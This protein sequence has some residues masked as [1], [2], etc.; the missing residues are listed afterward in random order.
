MKTKRTIQF[1]LIIVLAI[2]CSCTN[3]K[4]TLESLLQEMTDR[5]N[6]TYFPAPSYTVKQFSSY[7]QRSVSATQEG[8]FANRDYTHFIRKENNEG[9]REFVLFDD[10]GPGAVVRYW[11]TFAG[12]GASEGT[13]RI[14]IDNSSKPVL[15]DS[16]LKIL[17][18]GLLAKEPLSTSVSPK[19]EYQRRGHNLYLP[20][21]YAKH[22]KITYE[23]D[24]IKIDDNNRKP[25]IYYNITY[26]TYEKGTQ[27]ESFSMK[28]LNR[29]NSVIEN[30][31][32]KLKKPEI[33]ISQT[34][35]FPKSKLLNPGDTL[36]FRKYEKNR[37]IRKLLINLDAKDIKQALR[38]T[39]LSITFDNEQTVWC[40]IG[41]FFGTGYQ[42]CKSVTWYSEVSQD[43]LMISR[44]VMPFHENCIVKIINYGNQ[45]VNLDAAVHFSNYSWNNASMHFGCSWHE[46]HHL[47]TSLP[48]EEQIDSWHFDVNYID[49]EGRGVYAGDALTVFNTAD[50]W[51]GEGDEKIFVDDDIFPSCLGTGT[52]DY[53]GYAWCR[54]ETF[55]HP[56]IAQPAGNGNFHPG[57][58]VNMRYRTLDAM[59]F[60]KKIESDI[61]MWH[62]AKT[63]INYAMTSYWYAKPGYSSNIDPAPDL[64]K[65][66]VPVKRSDIYPPVVNE[67]GIIEG[68]ILGVVE[69]TNG[70]AGTQSHDKF[71]WSNDAQL[72]WRGAENGDLLKMNFIISEKGKYKVSGQFTKAVDYGM[73]N[74][75]INGNPV[76]GKFNGYL[77]Q[78]VKA[79]HFPLGTHKLNS[80]KN[81][82][83]IEI[84]GKDPQANIGYM[85]GI[86]FL[87]F[88]PF[89]QP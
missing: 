83:S 84:T 25:S 2:F 56:F 46:Y 87:K 70:T 43:G 4:I 20:L 50:A 3:E 44:W 59:P 68:E 57:M 47:N 89:K 24:S 78:G 31:A 76:N 16:V 48:K 27:V 52:E 1:G 64:V 63:K 51:W 6:L 11:M 75:K 15:E 77:S 79:F 80:G 88:E 54:P 17:S 55:T 9:R 7:D 42:A 60:N 13:L 74:I 5:E 10:N 34:E 62:W 45:N 28:V 73:I 41:D 86:D 33:D 14:Y 29:A 67:Q 85:A 23:C 53:Y 66:P 58:T 82:I 37:A 71:N 38:S 32:E 39:V 30:T 35:R 8:W 12:P 40:P 22:C 61:E 36:F 81:T 65:K 49:I 26:R 69:A 72:W 19:T 18:G 21:P